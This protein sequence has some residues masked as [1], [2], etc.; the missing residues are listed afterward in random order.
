MKAACLETGGRLSTAVQISGG[1]QYK[2][3]TAA[4]HIMWEHSTDRKKRCNQAKLVYEQSTLLIYIESVGYDLIEA[5]GGFSE[6]CAS[7]MGCVQAN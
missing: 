5:L 4:V 6:L 2:V 3:W 7:S 1:W